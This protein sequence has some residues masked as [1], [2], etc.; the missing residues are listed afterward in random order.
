M[1]QVADMMR[2]QEAVAMPARP[3]KCMR[4]ASGT[5]VHHILVRERG[6]FRFRDMFLEGTDLTTQGLHAAIYDAFSGHQPVWMQ[7]RPDF[8]AQRQASEGK[9]PQ[10]GLNIYRVYEVGSS[11]RAALYGAADL[12]SES[13]VRTAVQQNA[14]LQLEVVF[15]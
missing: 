6:G 10:D 2:A 14:C 3:C 12:D 11:Q 13:K 5:T 7:Q 1:C 4:S 9:R 8:L 15:L